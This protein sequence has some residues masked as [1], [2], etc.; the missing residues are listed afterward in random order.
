MKPTSRDQGAGRGKAAAEDAKARRVAARIAERKQAKAAKGAR[1]DAAAPPPAPAKL[2]APAVQTPAPQGRLTPRLRRMAQLVG[3]EAAFNHTVHVWD[4]P[5][6]IFL[7]NPIC[8]CSTLKM[9]LN[10]SVARRI[11]ARNFAITTAATIHSRRDN[12][13]KTPR[14][15]GY[16]RLEAMLDDPAVTLFAFVRNPESRFLSAFRKKL[17]RDSNHTARVRAHLGLP[18]EAPLEEVLTLE[19]FAAAVDADPRLR[20]LD[21]H[22]R[23]Q[24]R[25]IFFDELPRT[26]YGHVESF[27]ADVVPILE[28]LFGADYVLADA[29]AL[30]PANASGNRKTTGSGLS[31]TGRAHVAR[32]Y[33]GDFAMLDEIAKRQG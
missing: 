30:N 15:V 2:A 3:G 8:A 18:A 17:A 10:L 13:L 29:T 11:G 33:A 12:L 14:Q 31:E 4:D 27:A 32:A 28:G 22:W 25:Q 21:A 20:D 19:S 9:S 6:F 24:R 1:P 26:R 5:A 16:R 7:S 23:A